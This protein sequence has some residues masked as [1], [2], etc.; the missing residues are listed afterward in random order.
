MFSNISALDIWILAAFILVTLLADFILG[1]WGARWGGAAWKSIAWG[2]VGL[3]A[4]TF[5]IAVPVVGSLAGMFLGVLISE[6]YRTRDLDKANKAA[7]G[8]FLGWLLGMG[9]K[10]IAIFVFIILFILLAVF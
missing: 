6:M 8:S 4:G 10:L 9:F 7:V 5:I 1:L 3:V 2:L